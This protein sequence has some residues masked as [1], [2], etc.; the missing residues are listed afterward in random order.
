MALRRVEPVA[1]TEFKS[2]MREALSRQTHQL[3]TLIAHD[4]GFD[5]TI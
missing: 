2:R 1:S 5:E 4:V 3:I